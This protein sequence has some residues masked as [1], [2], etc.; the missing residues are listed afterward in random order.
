ML[1]ND[2]LERGLTPFLHVSQENT[3]ALK[4]YEDLGYRHRCDIGFWSLQR[5]G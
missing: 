5:P 4:L 2:N 1:G 3:R